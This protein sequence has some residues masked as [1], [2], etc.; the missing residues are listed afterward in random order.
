[1]HR[2]VVVVSRGYWNRR[3]VRFVVCLAFRAVC[4]VVDLVGGFVARTDA[5]AAV[6]IVAGVLPPDDRQQQARQETS[7]QHRSRHQ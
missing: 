5:V 3:F 7:K 2:D 1:M 4:S 6:V